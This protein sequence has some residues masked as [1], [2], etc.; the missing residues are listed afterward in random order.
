ME[1]FIPTWSSLTIHEKEEEVPVAT[2]IFLMAEA[3]TERVD[4]Q[5]LMQKNKLQ[6]S[7]MLHH[8]KFDV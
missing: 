1:S 6:M 2:S 5:V 8:V 4:S 7:V 3:R